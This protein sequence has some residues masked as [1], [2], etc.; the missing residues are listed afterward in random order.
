METMVQHKASM[1]GTMNSVFAHSS[2][3]QRPSAA[4]VVIAIVS[5]VVAICLMLPGTAYAVNAGEDGYVENFMK[6]ETMGLAWD[7]DIVTNIDGYSG[8]NNQAGDASGIVNILDATLRTVAQSFLA[9]GIVIFVGRLVGRAIWEMLDDGQHTLPKIL[10]TPEER[11]GSG[12]PAGTTGKR[13]WAF[14]MLKNC[15][16]YFAIA[17]GVWVLLSLIAS[18]VS[19]VWSAAK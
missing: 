7:E 8:G 2:V 17:V 15:S 16:F 3:K 13:A 1:T 11:K 4:I 6:N 5:A 14:P 12:S 10:Q 19:F 18:I 9:L